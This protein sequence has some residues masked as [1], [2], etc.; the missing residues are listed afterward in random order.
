[1]NKGIYRY[2]QDF[3][4]LLREKETKP[5]KGIDNNPQILLLQDIL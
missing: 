4:H 5:E 1:V 2:P 3:L